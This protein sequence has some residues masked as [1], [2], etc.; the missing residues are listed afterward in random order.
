MT[1][2]VRVLAVSSPQDDDV[3]YLFDITI[4]ADDEVKSKNMTF[5]LHGH[6][7][8]RHVFP[9]FMDS[10]GMIDFGS[11]AEVDRMR[12]TN[13]HHKVIRVG[14][15]FTIKDGQKETTYKITRIDPLDR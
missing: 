4:G 5:G 7:R 8:G 10:K 12:S 13:L 6:F 15:L 3:P 1:R 11:Y 2:H 14:E 9:F